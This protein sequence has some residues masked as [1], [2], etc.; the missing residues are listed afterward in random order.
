M[1]WWAGGAQTPAGCSAAVCSGS[2][3]RHTAGTA[4]APVKDS[5]GRR[6]ENQSGGS[7]TAGHSSAA[8]ASRSSPHTNVFGTGWGPWQ[9]RSRQSGPPGPAGGSGGRPAPPPG[10]THAVITFLHAV[11][12]PGCQD[13]LYVYGKYNRQDI[14]YLWEPV[15]NKLYWCEFPKVR[16]ER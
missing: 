5:W 6:S 7:G 13:E 15:K 10:L 1:Q 14:W 9:Q 11:L 2:P 3:A 4:A 12:L 16:T 8:P